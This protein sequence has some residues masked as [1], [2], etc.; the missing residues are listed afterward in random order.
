MKFP[1]ADIMIM[2]ACADSTRTVLRVHAGKWPEE[3]EK[4]HE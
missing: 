1:D 3:Y 2:Q 4:D